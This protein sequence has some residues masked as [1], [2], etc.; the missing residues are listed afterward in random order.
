MVILVQISTNKNGDSDYREC[1]LN[2]I[3]SIYF[4]GSNT[5]I[6]NVFDKKLAVKK[7]KNCK[8]Y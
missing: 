1:S 8:I 7:Q 2:D 5:V 3:K 4:K 6:S